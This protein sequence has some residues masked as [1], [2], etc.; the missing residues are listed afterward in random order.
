MTDIIEAMKQRHAVREYDGD[1]KIEQDKLDI[2]NEKIS[3]I[4]KESPSEAEIDSKKKCLF[5]IYETKPLILSTVVA[6]KSI[7]SGNNVNFSSQSLAEGNSNLYF[8]N[9]FPK[10]E[11]R[12]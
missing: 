2:L 6:E 8:A 4:N 11:H 12:Q 1:R 5:L 7:I 9:S 3:S 10:N